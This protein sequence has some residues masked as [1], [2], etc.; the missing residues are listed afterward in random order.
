MKFLSR[1]SMDERSDTEPQYWDW[2]E[3]S[4][5]KLVDIYDDNYSQLL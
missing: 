4:V 3:F 5:S 2:M 1:G